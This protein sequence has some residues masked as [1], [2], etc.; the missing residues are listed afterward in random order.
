MHSPWCTLTGNLERIG[1]PQSNRQDRKHAS[2]I[3]SLLETVHKPSQ[4]AIRPPKG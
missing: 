3:L 2:E 4:V 1:A